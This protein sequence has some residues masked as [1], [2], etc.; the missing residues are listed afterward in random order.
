MDFTSTTLR[1]REFAFSEEDFQALRKLQH[2]LGIGAGHRGDDALAGVVQG[3]LIHG[4]MRMFAPAL[5]GLMSQ[6][7][8]AFCHGR[9]IASAGLGVHCRKLGSAAARPQGVAIG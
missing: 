2:D 3:Q 7:V 5:I 6:A 8:K 9:S 1:M 4:R